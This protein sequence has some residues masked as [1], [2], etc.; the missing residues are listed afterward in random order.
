MLC[1]LAGK[2]KALLVRRGRK[3]VI[4]ALAHK[5]PTTVFLLIDIC[6]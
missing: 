4:F 3:P 1:G 6:D 5:L 2:F